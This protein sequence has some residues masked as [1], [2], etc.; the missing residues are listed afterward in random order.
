MIE[1]LEVCT[2][3]PL[4]EEILGLISYANP[5]IGATKAKIVIFLHNHF[6]RPEN[7]TLSA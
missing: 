2:I 1:I 7:F 3:V 5:N 4:F 6:L